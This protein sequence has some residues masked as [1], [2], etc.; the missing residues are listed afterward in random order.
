MGAS[1]VAGLTSTEPSRTSAGTRTCSGIACS[2][3]L[4]Q[5]FF[6]VNPRPAIKNLS[7]QL[8]AF[9]SF[10]PGFDPC[11]SNIAHARAKKLKAES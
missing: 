10:Q 9:S 5:S 11:P 7:Y 4:S 8:S 2:F 3:G 1:T 6:T